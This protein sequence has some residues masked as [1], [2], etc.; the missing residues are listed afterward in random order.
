MSQSL[1]GPLLAVGL[2]W[3]SPTLGQDPTALMRRASQSY[4]ALASFEA[5]F[6]QMLDD[7]MVGTYQ[8]KGRLNQAE[9][10]KF[11]M[12]FSDPNGEAIVLDGSYVWVYAPSTTPGQVIR[13]PMPR[14]AISGPNV[15]AWFLDRPTEKYSAAYIRADRVGARAVDVIALTPIDSTIPFKQATVWLDRQDALPRKLEILE[16]SG[17]HRTLTLRNVKVN[18][19]VAPSTFVFAVPPGVRIIDQA[20]SEEL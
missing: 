14:A 20:G 9:S 11:S 17:A 10:S 8:S 1:V 4:R 5:E 6:E 13:T 18:R 12:R 7:P 16:H 15:L 19:K 2:L 3:S